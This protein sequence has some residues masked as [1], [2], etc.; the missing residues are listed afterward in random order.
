M[1]LSPISSFF[2]LVPNPSQEPKK[3]HRTSVDNKD[4]DFCLR[5]WS[6]RYSS[7]KFVFTLLYSSPPS[8]LFYT[9]YLVPFTCATLGIPLAPFDSP[10]FFRT[11]IILEII[12]VRGEGKLLSS[13]VVK[14]ADISLCFGETLSYQLQEKTDAIPQR[15][16]AH[17]L[18]RLRHMRGH[19]AVG[20]C[21]KE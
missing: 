1:V 19:G 2:S 13:S 9:K 17:P 6:F 7:P 18:Y 11:H 3:Q 21:H 14:Q 8:Y 4:A 20:G 12:R 15:T 10:P 16:G 5:N